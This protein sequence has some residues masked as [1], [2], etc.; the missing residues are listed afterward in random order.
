MTFWTTVKKL[1]KDTHTGSDNVTFEWARVT[2]T[3]SVSSFLV[4]TWYHLDKNK[5]FDPIQFAS[6]LSIIIVA[7]SSGV[8]VK[9]LASKPSIPV[10]PQ[11]PASATINVNPLA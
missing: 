10:A 1:F 6:A 8:A 9:T 2:G 3:F 7:V 4:Y 11:T 5:T